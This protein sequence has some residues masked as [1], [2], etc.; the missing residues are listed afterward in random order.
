MERL[1][2]AKNPKPSLRQTKEGQALLTNARRRLNEAHYAKLGVSI[3]EEDEIIVPKVE[4]AKD[5]MTV[6]PEIKPE[7]ECVIKPT[8]KKLKADEHEICRRLVKKYGFENHAKM[9]RDI[10]LN[11]LQWSK[12]QVA[13]NVE[14]FRIKEGLQEPEYKKQ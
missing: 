11:Y 3:P 1:G 4:P 2:L 12:G 13:K 6:F 14:S 8:V 9:A 10:K 7:A 5:L